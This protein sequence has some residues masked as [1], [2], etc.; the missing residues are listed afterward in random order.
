MKRRTLLS[1]TGAA[2]VAAATFPAPAI[3]QGIRE[4]KLVVS[5]PRSMAQEEERLARHI[6]EISGGRLKVTVFGAGELVGAFEA[7]DAV[8][9]GLAEMYA[10]ADYYWHERSPAFNFFTSVPFGLTASEMITW[11]YR[12]GGQE[13]WD[14]LSAGFNIKPFA[15]GNSGAQMGGWY[16]EEMTSV[17]DF[18]ALRIRIPALG[19][20]M[21]RRLGAVPVLLGASEIVPALQSGALDAAEWTHP[22]GDLTLGLHT[23]AK[24]YYYPGVQDP[25][26]TLSLGVN[27]TLWDSLSAEE[28]SLITTATAAQYSHYNATTR[29]NA[30]QGLDVLLDEHGVQLHRFD[31]KILRTFGV[32]SGEVLAEIGASDPL[33]RRVYESYMKFHKAARRWTDISDRAYLNARALDF[34]YGI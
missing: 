22:W 23:A 7:F 11:L 29:F 6:T 16:N 3:A 13:L 9:E 17:D 10:S 14:E 30:A 8:S 5:W 18:K 15:M 1:A 27:K 4:L 20:E 25:G 31:D 32:L 12:G 21:L 2:A 19:G 26:A 24:Y 33:T 34:P 28:K